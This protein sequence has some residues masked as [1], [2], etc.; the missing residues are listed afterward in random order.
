MQQT[1]L[2]QT[3]WDVPVCAESVQGAPQNLSLTLRFYECIGPKNITSNFVNKNGKILNLLKASKGL[4]LDSSNKIFL[5]FFVIY[6]QNEGDFLGQIR[7]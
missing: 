7:P 5:F 2:M 6:L 1:S 3:T 4:T